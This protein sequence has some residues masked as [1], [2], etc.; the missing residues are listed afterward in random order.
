MPT[1]PSFDGDQVNKICGEGRWVAKFGE[2]GH[3]GE[4]NVFDVFHV[5]DHTFVEIFWPK[6]LLTEDFSLF[7]CLMCLLNVTMHTVSWKSL[8]FQK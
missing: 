3:N 5:S 1:Q 2:G 6:K 4:K 8:W 7:S